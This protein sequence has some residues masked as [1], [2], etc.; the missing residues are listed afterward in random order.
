M[1]SRA[2]PRF[3][4]L[5]QD[6]PADVQRLLVPGMSV[7]PDVYVGAPGAPAK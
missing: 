2:T 3:W 5:F 4:R 1:R 6:L 7:V